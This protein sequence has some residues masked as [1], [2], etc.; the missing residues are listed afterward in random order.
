VNVYFSA[1]L[2]AVKIPFKKIVSVHAYSDGVQIMRDGANA[3]PQIFKL[4]DP[5]FA[6]DMITRLNQ[7]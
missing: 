4:A 3:T 6:A 7:V 2:K 5:L 1:P